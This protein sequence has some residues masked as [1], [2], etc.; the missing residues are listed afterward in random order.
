M[1]IREIIEQEKE[2]DKIKIMMENSKNIKTIRRKRQT[3]KKIKPKLSKFL[4]M[5]IKRNNML[6]KRLNRKLLKNQLKNQSK[7]QY[8][9]KL[10]K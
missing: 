2:K 9:S 1:R 4:R 10:K 3:Q 8:K 7:N 6:I 5:K